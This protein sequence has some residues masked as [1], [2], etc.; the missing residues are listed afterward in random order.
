MVGREEPSED[1]KLPCLRERIM[2]SKKS[3]PLFFSSLPLFRLPLPFFLSSSVFFFLFSSPAFSL[4]LFS[5]LLFF[6]SPLLFPTFWLPHFLMLPSLSFLFPFFLPFVSFC[7]LCFFFFFFYPPLPLIFC[8]FSY[9]ISSTS[10]KTWGSGCVGDS[11]SPTI[12]FKIL[13]IYFLFF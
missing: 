7:L 9:K 2:L 5:F 8:F 4:S 12:F 13:F 3:Y 6:H 1:Q 11:M 10:L